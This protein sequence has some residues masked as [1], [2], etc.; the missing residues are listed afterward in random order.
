[1]SATLHHKGQQV[2]VVA[3]DWLSKIECLGAKGVIFDCDGTLVESTEAHCRS[4]Q[5]AAWDQGFVMAKDWYGART[6]LDRETLFCDFKNQV[7]PGLD[8]AKAIK[9][10]I[11]GFRNHI[12]T[13][14][15][16]KQPVKL[17]QTL[18]DKGCRVGV[19]TNAERE[20]ALLSLQA[21]GLLDRVSHLV[22]ISDG[23]PPKPAPQIFERAAN[24]MGLEREEVVVFEDSAQGVAA[25]LAAQMSVFQIEG[26]GK[27]LI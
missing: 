3:D 9:G 27:V 18:C 5:V 17:F 4:M 21:I 7:A 20:V 26:E 10:S 11:S 13:L 2:P 25:A 24:L 12:N 6:G 22:S 19:G 1:M 15:P 16:I 8:V 23:L 14:H